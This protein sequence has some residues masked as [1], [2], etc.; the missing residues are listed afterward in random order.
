MIRLVDLLKIAGDLELNP[1]LYAVI[2][3]VQGSFNQGN[4]SILKLLVAS[5]NAMQYFQYVGRSLEKF[6]D[7]RLEI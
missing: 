6:H 7:G 5:A 4:V 2:K 3:S 1:G